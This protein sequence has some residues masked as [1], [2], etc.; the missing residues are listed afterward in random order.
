M[1][2][3]LQVAPC[4]CASWCH[5]PSRQALRSRRATTAFMIEN[6][7]TWLHDPSAALHDCSSAALVIMLGRSAASTRS[8]SCS[9]SRMISIAIHH[10][11]G[12]DAGYK[13]RDVTAF[14]RGRSPRRSSCACAC[15]LPS[16]KTCSEGE[17]PI[18]WM[19][20]LCYSRRTCLLLAPGSP[21][22]RAS[23]LA[24]AEID[25]L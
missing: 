1:Y 7:F 20:A 11:P 18:V 17:Q 8:C 14:S 19:E 12:Q 2:I 10:P 6:V 13:S 4:F 3:Q 5:L 21:L 15:A 23:P 16:H 25:R 9:C 24:E 22:K